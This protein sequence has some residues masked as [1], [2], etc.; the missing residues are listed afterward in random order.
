M[1]LMGQN[2]LAAEAAGVPTRQFVEDHAARFQALVEP[3]GPVVRRLHPHQRRRAS[4]PGRGAPLAGL[5]RNG[6]LYKR[7]Y[8]G[9]YCGAVSS[10]TP[11]PTSW[12]GS[13]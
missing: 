11:P 3:P 12:A 4:R 10:S 7:A 9:D 13:P 1:F 6:D 5:R 8:E 2:V